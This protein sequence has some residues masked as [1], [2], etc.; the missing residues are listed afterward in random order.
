[1]VCVDFINKRLSVRNTKRLY[2][3]R[4]TL[5]N[6]TIIKKIEYKVV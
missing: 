2:I 3:G 1:M 6:L 4:Y 5:L